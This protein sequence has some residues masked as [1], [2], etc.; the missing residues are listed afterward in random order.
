MSNDSHRKSSGVFEKLGQKLT[1]IK[2][3]I[4]DNIERRRQPHGHMSTI[5]THSTSRTSVTDESF[6]TEKK[7]STPPEHR[8]RRTS[9]KNRKKKKREIFTFDKRKKEERYYFHSY[10]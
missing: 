1:N 10:T 6:I 5:Q 8:V 2:E 9:G 4:A 3:D 7:P